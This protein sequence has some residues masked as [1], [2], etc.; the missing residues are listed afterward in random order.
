MSH[1]AAVRL[2][3]PYLLGACAVAVVYAFWL[4]VDAR[5]PVLL[6]V[7]LSAIAVTAIAYRQGLI[8]R[9]TGALLI[10]GL[11]LFELGDLTSYATYLR[12]LPPAGI[13]SLQDCFYFAGY[14]FFIAAITRL[15]TRDWRNASAAIL[16]SV[17]LS[18]AAGFIL[19]ASVFSRF[20]AATV[21]STLSA[22]AYPVLDLVLVLGIAQAIVVVR[23]D[24][25]VS[26]PLLGGTLAFLVAD[27]NYAVVGLRGPYPGWSHLPGLY[28][29]AY[30]LLAT[31]VAAA[32][33]G[34]LT[35]TGTATLRLSQS[36]VLLMFLASLVAPFAL[37]AVRVDNVSA[38]V[39]AGWI[40]AIVVLLFAQFATLLGERGAAET[41]L[42]FLVSRMPALLWATDRDMRPVSVSGGAL[43]EL[44]WG[45]DALQRLAL[46]V[47]PSE[48]SAFTTAHR[49]ALKGETVDLE[50]LVDGRVFR[51]HVEPLTNA[52]GERVGTIGVGLDV[53]DQFRLEEQILHAQK[54]EAIGQIAGTIAHDFNNLLTGISGY[55]EF[56]AS[57]LSGH[58]A[59]EDIVEI[60][61]ASDRAASLTN[62]LA[63]FSRKQ[64]VETRVIDANETVAGMSEF[65]ARILGETVTVRYALDPAPAPVR[66]DPRQ[67]E[68]VILNLAINA[69]D[70]IDGRGELTI[71]TR[72]EDGFFVLEVED[73]GAGMDEPTRAR[74][75]DAFYTTKEPGKGTGLG[76]ASVL[77]IVSEAKGTIDVVSAPGAGATFTVSVPIDPSAPDYHTAEEVRPVV[78]GNE[79]ILLVDDN[80]LVR[81]VTATMLE[82]L[83]YD[84]VSAGTGNE[85]LRLASLDSFCLLLT[86]VVLTDMDGRRLAEQIAAVQPEITVVFISGFAPED[87]HQGDSPLVDRQQAYLGKPFSVRELATAIRSVLDD[88]RQGSA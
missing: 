45:S 14:P 12:G 34:R 57:K 18:M 47:D 71:S 70:A 22:A 32:S 79:S 72:T 55:A 27:L 35:S 50:Q 67:F 13:P 60:R 11:A 40:A 37:I 75:F 20:S 43:H 83:G 52:R 80:D 61:R 49:R 30:A 19:W 81:H 56:A 66:I 1:G 25:A 74:I 82:N 23:L 62:R 3:R 29:L 41:R 42:E 8:D 28:V 16:F 69:R 5:P 17:T 73:Q 31:G 54:L 63:I 53:T 86:D 33:P 15:Y 78:G 65:L 85:A 58:P 87:V 64:V 26:L 46:L 88:S 77:A 48:V 51:C 4:G 6:V 7:V 76:L 24:R 44:A 68:Q 2:R 39:S 9:A 21:S 36:R 10:G 38:Y 59:A 84:V